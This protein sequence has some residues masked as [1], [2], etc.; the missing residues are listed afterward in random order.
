MK[1]IIKISLLLMLIVSNVFGSGLSDSLLKVFDFLDNGLIQAVAGLLLV[2]AG[3][4]IAQK[5]NEASG[6][7]WA[8]VIGISI[9]YGA[10]GIAEALF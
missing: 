7:L 1:K 4:A 3:F 9:V 10:R 8:I 5:G 6:K 2:G